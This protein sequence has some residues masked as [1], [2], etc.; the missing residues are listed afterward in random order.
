MPGIAR[1]EANFEAE[2]A[3]G[4]RPARLARCR[5]NCHG[6]GEIAVM[7]TRTKPLL[8]LRP[9]GRNPTAAYDVVRFDFEDV[10]KVAAQRDLEL[11]AYAPHAVVGK[12]QILVQPAVDHSTDNEAERAIRNNAVG[13]RNAAIGEIGP[14]GIVGDRAA[15]QENPRLAIGVNSPT[16]DHPRIIEIETLLARPI[17]LTVRIADQQRLTVVDRCLV[18][19][20]LNLEWHLRLC[21]CRRRRYRRARSDSEAS[22]SFALLFKSYTVPA[23][24]FICDQCVCR[25]AALI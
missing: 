6:A 4:I 15:V 20:D 12:V 10:G 23:D 2:A 18:R 5:S 17:D 11:K 25:S 14:R 16:A 8:D 24:N 1:I 13:G 19:T 21:D 22:A 9:V 3:I 7:V